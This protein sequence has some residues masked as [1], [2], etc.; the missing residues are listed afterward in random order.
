MLYEYIIATNIY[1]MNIGNKQEKVTHGN[2]VLIIIINK[3]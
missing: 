3:Y 1:L 2:Y